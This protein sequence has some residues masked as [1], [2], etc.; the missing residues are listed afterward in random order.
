MHIFS[1]Q[2]HNCGVRF[3]PMTTLNHKLEVM[4][5]FSSQKYTH[6]DHDYNNLNHRPK[7]THIFSSQTYTTLNHNKY[8]YFQVTWTSLVTD[9]AK[10][11]IQGGPNFFFF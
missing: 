2:K 10:I 1:T 11:S 3:M 9:E 6:G 8:I 5:I 4:H 7:I